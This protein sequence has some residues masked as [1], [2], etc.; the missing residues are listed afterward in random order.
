MKK[1]SYFAQ[2]KSI[3][4]PVTVTIL[5]PFVILYFSKSIRLEWGMGVITVIGML[6]ILVGL[7]L[8]ITTITLFAQIGKGTLAPWDP[9]QKL[10]VLGPYRYVRNPMICGVLFIL[11]GETVLFGSFYLLLWFAYFWSRYDR[12]FLLR[13]EPQLLQRFGKEYQIYRENVP[14]W[15]PRI[16]PWKPEGDR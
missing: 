13:E 12:H 10:V 4:V 14:M 7:A 15:V 11:L 1:I 3:L 16:T 6:L 5:I 8:L 2:L 9:T